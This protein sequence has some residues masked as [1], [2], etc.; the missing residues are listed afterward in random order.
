VGKIASKVKDIKK[1]LHFMSFAVG[2]S[3]L[4]KQ[5]DKELNQLKPK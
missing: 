1:F 3:D 2:L 5:V 4:M